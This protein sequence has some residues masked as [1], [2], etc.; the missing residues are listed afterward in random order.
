MRTN[1]SSPILWRWSLPLIHLSLFALTWALAYFQSEPLLDGPSRWGFGMLFIA[2]VPL[3]LLGYSKMWDAK[4]GLGIA[5][6][7]VLGTMWWWA[8]GLAVE[9]LRKPVTQS[10]D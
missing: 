5:L 10:P 9:R 3:S 7:G 6:W 4:V 2:D 1:E 8:L